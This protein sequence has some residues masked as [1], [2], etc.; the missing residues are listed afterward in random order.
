MNTNLPS[1]APRA[2]AT[3]PA[4]PSRLSLPVC[5]LLALALAWA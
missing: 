1:Q 5:G 3:T 2:G 4:A